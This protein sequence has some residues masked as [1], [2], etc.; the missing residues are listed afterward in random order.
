M[1]RVRRGLPRLP[2]G[3][4]SNHD[5]WHC[6]C[7]IVPLMYGPAVRCKRTSSS[8]RL[9]VL[10]KCIRP[11][12]GAQAPEPTPKGAFNVTMR[13]YGSKSEALT[14]RWKPPPVTKK[15]SASNQAAH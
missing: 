13:L 6:P 5:R 3:N 7:R 14:V 4:W 15:Q 2:V 11:F 8:L 12:V 10:H 1:G 9:A